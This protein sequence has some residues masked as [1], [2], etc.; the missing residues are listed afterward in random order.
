MKKNSNTF[1][2]VV[3]S[4]V[5]VLITACNNSPA[6]KALATV[7]IS[8]TDIRLSTETL[9]PSPT[10]TPTPVPPTETPVPTETATLTPTDTPEPTATASV[11]P[12][13]GVTEMTFGY[14]NTVLIYFIQLGTG[15]VVACGDSA[16]GVG[17]GVTS[18]GDIS[19]DL[20]AALAKLFTYKTKMVSGLYN[21]LYASRIK[22]DSVQFNDGLA[23]VN[24]SG[25]YKPSG[26]DCDSLRVKAQIWLTVRQFPNVTATNIYLNG[27]P[28][29]DRV[30]ND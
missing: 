23:T 15:G 4:L 20:K 25:T 26:N 14:G 1:L 6:S 7:S 19:R 9:E 11:T 17:S 3:L 22:I 5:A 28:F 29:G 30:S 16:I 18:T 27:I 24:M 21:P 2:I 10:S 8:P 13:T 12:T